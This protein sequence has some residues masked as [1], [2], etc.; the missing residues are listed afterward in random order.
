MPREI[1]ELLAGTHQQKD[2]AQ[3]PSEDG[4]GE[5]T[6]PNNPN[7][8]RA[9]GTDDVCPICQE[10][11]LEVKLPVTW[12]RACSNAAHIRCMK[13]WAEHQENMNRG[14]SASQVNNEMCNSFWPVSFFWGLMAKYF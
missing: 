11:L 13:V 14:D 2:I 9:L 1:D 10:G 6:Q 12:C 3:P 8:Q 7:R 4:G 5:Y